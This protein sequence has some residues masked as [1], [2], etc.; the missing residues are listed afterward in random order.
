MQRLGN[1][2]SYTIVPSC[3]YDRLYEGGWGTPL[4]SSVWCSVRNIYFKI[5]TLL[6]VMIT[7][8][9]RH[10]FRRDP[11]RRG[12]CRQ[13]ARHL[14]YI[15]FF[16]CGAATQRW[17][18][19]PHS[20]GFLDHTQR[21]TTVGRAP[22]DE[23]SARRRDLY[24][25]THNT[26]NRQNIHAPGGIRTHDLSRRAAADLYIYMCTHTHTHTH[27]HTDGSFK[28]TEIRKLDLMFIRKMISFNPN[29]VY[30]M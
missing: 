30:L 4:L 28:I 10:A 16:F 8:H 1:R 29:Y 9:T 20:W 26:H 11:C 25:T 15:Y 24:L 21:R 13:V 27:T 19:P 12:A 22:L 17:S 3:R 7:I 6:G 14:C 18:W 2:M 23:W 5:T